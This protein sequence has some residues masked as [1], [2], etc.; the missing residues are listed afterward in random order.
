MQIIAA[1]GQQGW[2]LVN[3]SVQPHW[4]IRGMAGN[5][6]SDNKGWSVVCLLKRPLA[7]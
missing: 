4:F 6:R 7:P 5:A 1:L 2:E 3:F